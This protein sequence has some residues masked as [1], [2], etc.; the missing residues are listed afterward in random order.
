MRTLL[1]MRGL[2]ASGK[3]TWIRTHGL[4][5]YT[6]SPDTLRLMASSPVILPYPSVGDSGAKS[7]APQCSPTTYDSPLYAIS[8]KNDKHIWKMLFTLLEL[9]CK[10]GDFT[11][12]DATHTSHQALRAY[13]SLASTYRYRLVVLD[14][15]G[16]GFDEILTR[17]AKRGY[18]AVPE[19][20]LRSMYER[21]QDSLA[22]PLPSRYTLLHPEDLAGINLAKANE[23]E[24]PPAQHLTSPTIRT[25]LMQPI[26]LN[27]YEQIHHI[28]DIHGCFEVLVEYLLRTLALTN[29]TAPYACARAAIQAIEQSGFSTQEC[30]KLI[31]E[32]AYYIFLGDYIDRGVENAQIVRFLL[33]IMECKNICLLEGNHERWLHKWGREDLGSS[34]FALFTARDLA[35]TKISPKDTHRLHAKLRQCAYYTFDSKLVLCTHGGLSTL[36]HNLLLIPTQLLIY[37]SGGYEDMES[38]AKSFAATTQKNVYQV[39]GHRNREKHAPRVHG[40][41]FALEGGVEFGKA[42]RACIL[43]KTPL[44][45]THAPRSTPIYPAES[46]KSLP[47]ESL[48]WL[49]YMQHGDGFAEIMLQSG[50]T[51]NHQALLARHQARKIAALVEKFRTSSLI[52]ERAFGTISSFNFTKEAFLTKQWSS[53]TCKA[54]GLFIDTNA[55][56]ICARS[57][58]KFFNL[59][60][61][62]ESSLNALHENLAYPV[63]VYAKENGFLGILSANPH[64]K[65]PESNI[66]NPGSTLDS[67]MPY[68]K[69]SSTDSAL[70]N[71]Y[72]HKLFITSKSDALSP[73][74][75]IAREIITASLEKHAKHLGIHYNEL[76]SRLFARLRQLDVSLVFEIIDPVQDPHIIAY[77]T[78]R[79]I[80]LDMIENSQQ[81]KKH[82]YGALVEFGREFGFDVKERLKDLNCWEEFVAFVDLHSMD[83]AAQKFLSPEST[84]PTNLARPYNPESMLYGSGDRADGFIEGFVLEDSG[85]FMLKIKSPYYRAWK[86]ARAIIE[87]TIQSRKVPKPKTS[88]AFEREFITWLSAQDL[89]SDSSQLIALR[90]QFLAKRKQG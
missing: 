66:E 52:K 82:D 9:R 8:Q 89:P 84:H 63:R 29:A 78:T 5:P 39:F 12:I 31:D 61:R 53:I 2:P 15:S 27:T 59:G 74:A 70:R 4:E 45:M 26:D 69:D 79:A 20:I 56:K 86:A 18:K 24:N 22:N 13:E 67:S 77:D 30:S 17:N 55:Y 88:S 23:S 68:D 33:A 64:H 62:E 21:L 28:G 36:P 37:G 73:Y 58:E 76:E 49:S 38:S 10:Q 14:F 72:A 25:L 81:F 87:R 54:R 3:S 35:S 85:G 40:R 50:K 34:E 60:E 80:L 51:H 75:S 83:F 43:S 32:R 47:L 42:L 44:Q 48:S 57:Y 1:L 6:L 41:S 90:S 71:L 7:C 19:S 16:V 11:I 46:T 65:N